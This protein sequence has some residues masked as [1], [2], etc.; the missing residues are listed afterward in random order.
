MGTGERAPARARALARPM[1]DAQAAAFL[2]ELELSGNASRAAV[3]AG[4]GPSTAYR[5][6]ARDGGFAA[7][8]EAAVARAAAR[9]AGPAG[10]GATVRRYAGHPRLTAPRANEWTARTERAF[11]DGL[12]ATANAGAA[13]TAAGVSASGA[14]LRRRRMPDFAAAWDEAVADGHARLEMLL[15][16]R[17]ATMLGNGDGV[18]DRS[19][20]VTRYEA[21][22]DGAAPAG[23]AVDEEARDGEARAAFDPYIAMWLLKR[24]DQIRAGTV[25]RG[26]AWERVPH[27]EEV[28]ESIM[29]K[30]DAIERAE[31]RGQERSVQNRAAQDRD[32]GLPGT[33]TGA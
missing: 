22:L 19:D 26:R 17:G 9:I 5:R 21:A 12:S 4:V 10:P 29:R 3:I 8:W 27:I 20:D 1:G 14:W 28:R 6:R 18:D 16:Q 7:A 24:R 13:A 32:A 31:T 11:L 23:A 15:M 30:L 33:A 25:R 2:G